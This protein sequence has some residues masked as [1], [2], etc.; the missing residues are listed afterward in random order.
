MSPVDSLYFTY[1]PS[2][3]VSVRTVRFFSYSSW[4]NIT[5]ILLVT[6]RLRPELW[7]S[8]CKNVISLFRYC[9]T[10]VY[11][12]SAVL[13]NIHAIPLSVAIF[14]AIADNVVFSHDL[15]FCTC[16]TV[17]EYGRLVALIVTVAG[18]PEASTLSSS[19]WPQS[20]ISSLPSE[21]QFSRRITADIFMPLLVP[22]FFSDTD[23]VF[24]VVV[25]FCVEE[26]SS[27]CFVPITVRYS[28]LT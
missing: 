15:L 10:R 7:Q 24:A 6:L 8:C 28:A 16:L 14:F 2:P 9:S 5:M 1:L 17:E 20:S 23:I 21:F 25:A 4:S 26:L 12:V 13:S 22:F 11:A 27:I 19:N 3:C 18:G